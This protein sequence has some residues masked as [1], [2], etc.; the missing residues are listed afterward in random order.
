MFSLFH[1]CCDIGKVTKGPSF[2][3]H[4]I[5]VFKKHLQFYN[6]CFRIP[7]IK[8]RLTELILSHWEKTWTFLILE[9]SQQWTG[10]SRTTRRRTRPKSRTWTSFCRTRRTR[11]KRESTLPSPRA[12]VEV[13]N[14]NNDGLLNY[15]SNPKFI[16]S[17]LCFEQ[18]LQ[19]WSSNPLTFGN[20]DVSGPKK[21][22]QAR[23]CNLVADL[24]QNIVA[25]SSIFHPFQNVFL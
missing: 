12:T 21:I 10:F 4:P 24:M 1:F 18:T 17:Y 23:V 16:E 13:R 25:R 19:N 6:K 7:P 5:S 22:S 3:L 2:F 11:W 9:N 8:M 20:Q 15:I 14:T